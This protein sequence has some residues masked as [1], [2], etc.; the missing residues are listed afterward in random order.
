[1]SRRDHSIFDA[2]L[3]GRSFDLQLTLRLLHRLHPYRRRVAASVACIF[4]MALGAVLLPVITTRVVID[5]VLLPEPGRAAPDFGM[6]ELAGLVTTWTGLPL[7]G[8][9][10]LLYGMLAA[11]M[12]GLAHASR[13]LLSRAAL[14]GLRDLRRDLFVHLQQ[15]SPSFYD[16]VAV[17]RVMTRV[18]NDVEVLYQLLVGFGML[19]GE[20]VPFFLA[21]GLMLAADAPLAGLMLMAIPVLAGATWLFRNATRLVYRNIRDSVSRLNQNLQENLSGIGVVQLHGRESRNLESY[22]DINRENRAC[23]NQAIRLEVTYGAFI[24]SLSSVALA[25]IVWFGG[26]QQLGGAITL[27]TL[28]LFARYA[29]LLFRPIVAVGEQ[30]NVLY[31]AMASAER[32]FQLLDWQEHVAEPSGSAR[33]PARLEGRIEFRGVSFGYEPDEPVLDDVTLSISPGEKL[34]VVGATGAGKTTLARLLGRFYDFERGEVLLDGIDVR[35]L[36]AREV[37]RR[38]GVVLQD[39]H[40]FTGTVRDNI[41]LWNPEIDAAR[42]EEAARLVHAD[43]FIRALPRGY[44]TDL[45]ERG[46]NLSHGERQLLSFARVLA[47]DPE[48]L[49]LDEATASVDPETERLIQQAL[50]RITEGRTSI[51]IAHRLLT[52]LEADRI[53][54]MQQGRIVESGSHAELLARNGVYRTLY[55]L[56]F[57]EE[58]A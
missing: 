1:M 54:V 23:E 55:E 42:V 48:I 38:L 45:A 43:A 39:F 9:A 13:L 50:H 27:G 31:R 26:L 14:S 36:P 6:V 34:A 16:K 49:I 5:G 32:I 4:G 15:L 47:A 25:V 7:L 3:S 19:V 57:R 12:L 40:I 20:M 21:L 17:G 33:L 8:A 11:G 30:Y 44:D 41:A 22:R 53:V 58:A 10:V 18:T 35:R 52:L 46:A 29:D 24:D 51:L 56:Q 37:R 2:E 28:I